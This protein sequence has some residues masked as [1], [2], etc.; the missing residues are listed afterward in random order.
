MNIFITKQIPDAGI[1]LL[2][3]AGY[4][5]TVHPDEPL[6]QEKLIEICK[7][8]DALIS[9]GFNKIDA[10]F[11]ESC[12]N[13][14]VVSLFSVGY[15]SV[16]V[17]AATR[18]KIPVGNTPDVLSRATSDIAF[19]LMLAVSRRAFYNYKKILDGKW[20]GFEPT[21]NLGQELYGKTIGIWGLGKIGWEMAQ[22]CKAAF[23]MN[24]I[25]HNRKPHTEAEKELGATY[26]SF[27]ELLRQSD[28]LSLHANLSDATKGLF[29][30][31]AFSRM[32]PNAIFINTGRGAL[33]NEA[34][35]RS[36]LEDGT[37]W[38]AG[39]DVT[40]PEPMDKNNPLLLMP[41]VCILP[42]IG[43]ATEE[44]RNGMA[45]MAAKNALAGLKG[46]RLPTIVNPEVYD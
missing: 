35:L 28:V 25:Y 36:A 22:K 5:V 29:N 40:N 33:H 43:S 16:D 9:A 10:H 1:K 41:N 24:V 4:E 19:L 18:L 27:D 3:E 13:L 38:G 23:G 14:K 21:A 39:L 6:P 42:H 26:V 34:D 2:Q 15:D 37:I 11:L 12:Q 45:I 17:A 7:N 46:E 30:K 32:K 8:Y 44:A 31:A 20:Q